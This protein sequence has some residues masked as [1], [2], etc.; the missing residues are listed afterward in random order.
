MPKADNYQIYSEKTL[1]VVMTMF[2]CPRT[3]F[4]T[5]F[6]YVLTNFMQN[7]S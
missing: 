2:V 1:K 4:E 3:E 7:F 6:V 5:V